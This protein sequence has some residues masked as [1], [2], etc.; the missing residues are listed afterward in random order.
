VSDANLLNLGLTTRLIN[1]DNGLE[2]MRLGIVQK[3]LFADQRITQD[4][5]P[6]ITQRLSDL[7]LL[8]STSVIPYWTVDS[9][10]Q[11]GSQRGRIERS[12]LGARYSP[13]PWRTVGVS[14]SYSRANSEQLDLT[15]QW[16]LSG[17]TPPLT[18][19]GLRSVSHAANQCGGAWYSV[20]KLSYSVRD[21]RLSNGLAGFEYD[22]GC[23]IGRVVAEQTAVGASYSTRILFQLELIGL[24]RLGT[25]ALRAMTTTIPGY[26]PLRDE[27]NTLIPGASSD[28]HA[29]DD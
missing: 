5:G 21:R 1:P 3:V 13:G 29:Y 9:T 6:A 27:H 28:F 18:L 7:L 22:G 17:R 24:S 8:G 15:W 20:G 11:Y 25:S 26:R 23:W 12:L 2:A 10:L 16:P 4:D 19:D 14:Y